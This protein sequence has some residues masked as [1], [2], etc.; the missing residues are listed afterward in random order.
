MTIDL[1]LAHTLPG[2]SKIL[3]KNPE[4]SEFCK[5]WEE[6]CDKLIEAIPKIHSVQ[7]DIIQIAEIYY[8]IIQNKSE[9]F[10]VN[11]YDDKEIEKSVKQNLKILTEGADFFHKTLVTVME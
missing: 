10:R 8:Q 5:L 4:F 1:H 11:E 9:K 2:Y 7:E 3:I 6:F